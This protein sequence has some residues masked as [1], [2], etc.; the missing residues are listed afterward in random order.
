M[1]GTL[2]AVT[3]AAPAGALAGGVFAAA[4]GVPGATAAGAAAA[5]AAAVLAGAAAAESS[6]R[7]TEPSLTLSPSLTL[8]LLDPPAEG[9]GVH[10]RLVGFEG[11]QRILRLDRVARFDEYVD[12]RHVSEITDVG[13]LD[14]DCAHAD[15]LVRR[16]GR[17]K[18]S[19][20]QAWRDRC[21]IS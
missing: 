14:F 21:R 19:T 8:E 11:N 17:I 18:Q 12:D 1:S 3:V 16:L 15:T 9:A 7:M 6:V 20:A 13:D 4:V 2:T 10:R 5:D